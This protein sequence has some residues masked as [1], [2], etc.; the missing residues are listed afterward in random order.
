MPVYTV[1]LGTE[2][3]TIDDHR[4]LRRNAPIRVPPDLETLKAVAETTGGKFFEA[5]DAESLASV[6]DEI[7]SQVGTEQETRELTVVFTAAGAAL[8]TLGG[9]LS[10]LWFNRIP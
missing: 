6:Y 7:G 8:L 10:A 1:A 4:R 9:L 2:D 5:A 3:G